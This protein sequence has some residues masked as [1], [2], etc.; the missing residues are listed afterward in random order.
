[1]LDELVKKWDLEKYLQDIES[2]V[3]PCLE[4]IPSKKKPSVGHSKVGG[5]PDVEPDFSW[6]F[7]KGVPLEFIA[8]INCAEACSDILPESGLLLFFYDNRSYGDSLKDKGYIRVHYIS[9]LTA[10]APAEPPKIEKKRLWGLLTPCILPK[11]YEEAA[12]EF[13]PVL[14]L[15]VEDDLPESLKKKWSTDKYLSE[16]SYPELAIELSEKRFIQIGGHANPVQNGG[17][18]DR[19]SNLLGKGTKNQWRLIFEIFEHSCTN[20]SWGD[21]GKLHFFTHVDDIK[22]RNF[23]DAWMEFQCH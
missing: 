5:K 18:E 14:S 20:M 19:I 10:L 22:V 7:F 11:V 4:G 6:P 16:D 8:Q 1:M 21:A 9:E 17:I 15:P 12:I 2:V 13:R 3:L 23:D